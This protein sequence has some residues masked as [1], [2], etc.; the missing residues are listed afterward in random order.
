MK[1]SKYTYLLMIEPGKLLMYNSYRGCSSFIKFYGDDAVIAAN[2]IKTPD[3]YIN[4]NVY[5]ILVNEGMLVNDRIDEDEIC[6]Q[7]AWKR[8]FYPGLNLIIMPTEDCNFRCSY[9]YEE[10]K[11]GTMSINTAESIVKYVTKNI[12]KYTELHVVWFGG[13]TPNVKRNYR[14]YTTYF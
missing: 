6:T 3:E 8:I 10:H 1:K 12:S 13:G 9:C 7:I 2:C 14:P 11:N 4:T 5:E